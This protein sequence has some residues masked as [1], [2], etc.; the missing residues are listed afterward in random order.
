[1]SVSRLNIALP[2]AAEPALGIVRRLAD[3]GHQALFNGGCVRDLLLGLSP[4]DFDVVTSAPP[5]TVMKLFRVTRHVGVQFGVVLVRGGG[6][7]IEVATFRTDG[8][9]LDGRR[10]AAVAFADAEADALRR[11]FTING[12]FFNPLTAELLDYVGG[13]AD[14]A[15]RRIRAIGDPR[16][17]YCEDYLRLLRTVRF[18]ARLEFEIEPRTFAAMREFAAKTANVAPERVREELEK[19]LAHPTRHRAFELMRDAGTLSHLWPGARWDTDS[20]RTAG[21]LLR[22]LPPRATFQAALTALLLHYSPAE[23]EQIAR[24]LTLSNRQREDVLWLCQERA[25]LDDP[26]VPSLAELKRRM[27]NRAFS[28]LVDLAVARY[29]DSATGKSHEKT[30]RD[31]VAEIPP[32]LIA[33]SPLIV[34]H[35]L[36]QRRIEAGPVFKSVLDQLYTEQLNEQLRNRSDALQRLDAILRERGIETSQ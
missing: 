36:I 30:L 29:S 8:E 17:R 24:A 15:A 34:G 16:A 35:D 27:S 28:D 9:Y 32:E 11:D 14:L 5:D 26:A 20:L 7:W 22:N 10:P 25:F 12:M 19:M 33:P 1:M 31:R 4:H 3:A 21:L 2:P 13:Q 6:Q 18:A 23:I